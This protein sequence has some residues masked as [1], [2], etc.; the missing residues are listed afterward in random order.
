MGNGARHGPN[1]TPSKP[2]PTKRFP[3]FDSS[4]CNAPSPP[5][6]PTPTS[7]P[8][9]KPPPNPSF[10]TYASG[11]C[12]APT[13]HTASNKPAHHSHASGP[14][15]LGS[16]LLVN[17]GG[18][19]QEPPSPKPILQ[20]TAHL[21]KTLSLSAPVRLFCF[22]RAAIRFATTAQQVNPVV[23]RAL[24]TE[25]DPFRAERDSCHPITKTPPPLLQERFLSSH[26]QNTTPSPPTE[27]PVI[28]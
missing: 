25:P 18:E 10:T 8:P 14:S 1:Q 22:K 19:P 9:L 6:N 27:I 28:P 12:M 7:T 2:A 24:R 4:P 17:D 23:L 13:T 26:N 20:V 16:R 5:P 15:R 21:N 3:A 11:Q